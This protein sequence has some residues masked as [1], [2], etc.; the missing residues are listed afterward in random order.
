MADL[1]SSGT[2]HNMGAVHF[3]KIYLAKALLKLIFPDLAG[4][5]IAELCF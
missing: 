4:A 1:G 2:R 3:S 5:M